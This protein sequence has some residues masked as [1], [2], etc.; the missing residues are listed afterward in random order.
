MMEVKDPYT[1]NNRWDIVVENVQ[2][3]FLVVLGDCNSDC[4]VY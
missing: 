4:V 3:C 1:Y 2:Y